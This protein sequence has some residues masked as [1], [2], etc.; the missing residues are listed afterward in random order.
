MLFQSSMAMGSDKRCVSRRWFA[1]RASIEMTGDIQSLPDFSDFGVFSRCFRKYFR[2]P[3]RWSNSDRTIARRRTRTAPKDLDHSPWWP[4]DL[5]EPVAL[6]YPWSPTLLEKLAVP[7]LPKSM[8]LTSL[9]QRTSCS[10][11]PSGCL[12]GELVE[13]VEF[14]QRK[15]VAKGPIELVIERKQMVEQSGSHIRAPLRRPRLAAV[16]RAQAFVRKSRA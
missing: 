13:G 4:R 10:W 7:A 5:P 6:E 1:N 14:A 2:G 9:S 12:A 3:V 11:S 15:I 16:P 8:G